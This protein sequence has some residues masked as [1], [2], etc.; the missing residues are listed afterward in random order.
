MKKS[1]FIFSA[2]VMIAMMLSSCGSGSS[3]EDSASKE[4]GASKEV[5]IGKQ[6]WMTENLNV[7]IFR[8]GEVV[9]EAK[10]E[11][12]WEAYSDAEEAAWCYY[13]NDPANGEK[14]GKLYN[15]YAVNDPRGLAPK[16][17]HVPTDEEWT[18]LKDYLG[19]F[20]KA[21]AKMKSK[22]GWSQNGIGTN[23]SGL[24]GLPGGGRY[25][26]YK[27]YF[28]DIGNRGIWWSSTE[29]DMN[30]A[31]SH[32]LNYSGGDVGWHIQN[33]GGGFSVRCLRD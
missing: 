1:S 20:D 26:D 11:G 30:R 4:D 25:L 21:G 18:Q 32:N 10:T 16:G 19:G 9:P 13:D 17:W 33:K 27:I 8:N 23:S 6:V 28:E 14:Y 22:N 15:W 29:N 3:K 2:V 5:T 7:D 12:E 31:W 24:L